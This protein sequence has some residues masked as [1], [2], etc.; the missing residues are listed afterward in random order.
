MA[1]YIDSVLP[2]KTQSEVYT[3]IL[4]DHV[5]NGVPVSSWRSLVNVGLSLTQ[6]VSEG[7]ATARSLA[8]QVFRGLFVDSINEDVAAAPSAAA[9]AQVT[10]AAQ[11]FALSQYQEPVQPATLAL[12]RVVLS[13]VAGA[14]VNVFAAGTVVTGTPSLSAP[15][16]YTLAEPITLDPSGRVV[17]L[18][19]ASSPGSGYN[20]AP[21]SAF[22]MKT[23]FVGVSAAV[24]STGERLTVGT[25]NSSLAL[26][27]GANLDLNSG[28][29]VAI[30][31][32]VDGP[33]VGTLTVTHATTPGVRTTVTVH[34]RSDGASAPLSTASEI[35][36][37]I[38]AQV[39]ASIIAG[40]HIPDGTTGLG[41]VPVSGPFALPRAN[42]PVQD[43]GQN[44]ETAAV[45]MS[46]CVAKWDAL[47]VG[48]GTDDAL[49]YWVTKIPAGY[50]AS[51]VA[52]AQVINA[53]KPDGTT[54]GGWVTVLVT[55]LLGPLSVA[56]LAAV[57][58][59]L[60]SPRK[61]ANFAR[62]EVVN[63]TTNTITVTAHVKYLKSYKLTDADIASAISS[64]FTRLQ[65]RLTMGVQTIDPS[66][67]EGTIFDA[68]PAVWVVTLSA[69]AAPTLIA[70]NERPAF[71]LS[72]MTYEAVDP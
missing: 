2:V 14:S 37:A 49:Y 5:A 59:N 22:E 28:E 42:G 24:P 30:E 1:G 6:Y 44:E 36:S 11:A 27:A 60:Y 65:E 3:E 57:T 19:R 54:R 12:L 63:A 48:T 33:S 52:Q 32:V 68:S 62:V 7:A 21:D 39:P 20:L 55:G 64:A 47:S 67:V 70:W 66:L 46:R 53:R 34:E 38:C 50:T 4:A 26:S 43:A 58:A 9:L 56:D 18:M 17:A 72:G 35:R 8:R 23:T 31:F 51:P 45:Q 61:F 13:A 71:A 41:V 16:L 15:L 10:A 40:V 29:E 69:P 25:G